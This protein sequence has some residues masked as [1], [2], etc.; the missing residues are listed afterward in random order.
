M[1][2]VTLLLKHKIFVLLL[3]CII[4]LTSIII[5]VNPQRQ[6]STPPAQ[7]EQQLVNEPTSIIN[8]V[9]VTDNPQERFL[10]KV[11]NRVPL[12]SSDN[13]AKDRILS[14]LPSGKQSGQ[15]FR[16]PSISIEYVSSA[17]LFQVE[18]FTTTIDAAKN[19]AV[20]WFKLQG[21]SQDGICNYPINFYLNFDIKN[22]LGED[23][24]TFNPLPP[25]C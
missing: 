22:Q 20:N 8:Q 1:S 5:L 23:A 11:Q 2:L 12:S 21:L 6:V 18:I 4:F 10:H 16:S 19:E 9:P 24:N 14:M 25:G 15:L 7:I 3:G 17:N 13:A